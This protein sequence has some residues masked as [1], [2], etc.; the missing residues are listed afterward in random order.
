MFGSYRVYTSSQAASF[1]PRK[2]D[3]NGS[4]IQG[5]IHSGA[6]VGYKSTGYQPDVLIPSKGAGVS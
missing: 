6:T 2:I 1:Q 5:M 4:E 3:S